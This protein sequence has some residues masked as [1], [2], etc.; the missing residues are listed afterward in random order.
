MR[1]LAVLTVALGCLVGGCAPPAPPVPKPDLAADEKAIRDMDA[2][3][4]KA[5]QSRDPGAEAAFFAEDGVAYREHND[6]IVGPSAYQA[7]QTKFYADNPKVN[8]IWSTDAIRIAES[9][10]LAIQTGETRMTGLGPKGDGEDRVR[11]VTVWKKVSGQ[12]KA[13]HD[14]GSTTMPEPTTEKK[15]LQ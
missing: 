13:A 1:S 6:P 12:W 15:L 11:F 2:R 10:D 14:I 4:L 9:G 8:T 5:A 7:F 3:W